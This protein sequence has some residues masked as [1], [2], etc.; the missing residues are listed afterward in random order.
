MKD[1]WIILIDLVFNF[2]IPVFFEVEN[3]FDV[4]QTKRIDTCKCRCTI[5]KKKFYY[6]GYITYL[7]TAC[8]LKK[9][10]FLTSNGFFL[11]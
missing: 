7:Y 1:K 8:A 2:I 11:F 9:I 5:V 4:T 6:N 10:S 3:V